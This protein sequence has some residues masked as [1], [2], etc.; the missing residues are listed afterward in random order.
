M[1]PVVLIGAYM[2]WFGNRVL[3]HE[4]SA[5][6]KLLIIALFVLSS[7]QAQFVAAADVDCITPKNLSVINSS[8][9]TSRA[10][11][12]WKVDV[13]KPCFYL[14]SVGYKREAFDVDAFLL[15]SDSGYGQ[16][17]TGR[18]LRADSY[19]Q[20]VLPNQRLSISS[21]VLLSPPEKAQ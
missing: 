14:I 12:S 17:V 20:I 18:W 16:M 3:K 21:A 7:V 4:E 9:S 5:L 10:E 6:K 13:S 2:R 15:D 11:M 1:R 8:S 19:G